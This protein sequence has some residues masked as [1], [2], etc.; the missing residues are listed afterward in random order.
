MDQYN[1]RDIDFSAAHQNGQEGS[2]NL[3]QYYGNWLE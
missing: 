2:E 1:W 3:K